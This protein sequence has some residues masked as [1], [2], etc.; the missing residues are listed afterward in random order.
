MSDGLGRVEQRGGK[1][2]PVNMAVATGWTV[3]AITERGSTETRAGVQ[4]GQGVWFR[5]GCIC[6]FSEIGLRKY[7]KGSGNL[8]E[9]NE[10]EIS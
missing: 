7:Y 9:K 10:T 1:P 4:G 5:T 6:G 8:R 3:M 2:T